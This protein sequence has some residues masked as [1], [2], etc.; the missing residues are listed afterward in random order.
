MPWKSDFID[1]TFRDGSQSLWAMGIRHGMM[2]PIAEDMDR[3]GFDAIDI[4]ANPIFF[5]K[6]IRDLKEDP[7]ELMKML[8][9]KMPNTPKACMGAGA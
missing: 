7:W 8:A 4:P 1:K 6:M 5:K 3:A 2:E 9:K